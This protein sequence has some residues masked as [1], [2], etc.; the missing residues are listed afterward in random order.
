MRLLLVEDDELFRQ[1]LSKSLA[2][3]HYIIDAV[4]DGKIAWGY[5]KTFSYDL[6][7]LDVLLPGISG[8]DFCRE[9]RAKG[10]KFPILLLSA[11]DTSI[12]RIQGLDAGA[13]DFVA[14]PIDIEE[15][16]ARIRA[17]LRRGQAEASPIL[18]CGPLRIDPNQATT[19]YGGCP[20]HLTSKKYALLELLIRNNQR[21]VSFEKI[22]DSLWSTGECP[23]RDTVRS[24]IKDL[25]QM[26]QAAGAPDNTIATVRGRGYRLTLPP[27]EAKS[28]DSGA[29]LET[30]L[31]ARQAEV[32]ARQDRLWEQYRS[33]FANRLEK[34]SAAVTQLQET[35]CDR[36]VL[37]NAQREAHN[38]AGTL[39]TFGLVEGTRLARELEWAL[40]GEDLPD[41]SQTSLLSSL[42]MA[43]SHEIRTNQTASDQLLKTV[44]QPAGHLT[45][46]QTSL[47]LI[48]GC[49]AHF[50]Q[51][52]V[53][54]AHAAGLRTA[55]A[56]NPEE[57]HQ[58]VAR[59]LP[60]VAL[61][62]LSLLQAIEAGDRSGMR[63]S[64]RQPLPSLVTI[65]LSARDRLCDRLEATRLGASVFLK[66]SVLPAQVLEVIQQQL[67]DR[68][69]AKVIIVDDDP[70][71]LKQ[72]SILLKPWGLEL[73]GLE[74]PR[75]FWTMLDAIQ[76]DLVVL[77]VTM[78]HI[79]GLELCQ[80]IRSDPDWHRL[81]VLFLT[82]HSDPESR[83]QAFA[84][85]ADD[86]V[87]KPVEAAELANR[88]L[89]RLS[90]GQS[91]QLA[92]FTT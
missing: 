37:K 17:L 29:P 18:Q 6:L 47:V 59:E 72:L 58:S 28:K 23:G 60:A 32:L 13:D 11:R 55:I 62:E 70:E 78:P 46:H 66:S 4:P 76:P 15:L 10:F 63:P 43:L 7:L 83:K 24:H 38:L 68:T 71:L 48:A 41:S 8:I 3:R 30:S 49:S 90:R 67:C 19:T 2:E 84:L 65:A 64:T 82:A 52:M 69:G 36:T 92:S 12:N 88:I 85:G 40:Q 39:G 22:F 89:N 26:L 21:V 86:Y 74:D 31:A 9:I 73:T 5:L 87:N 51:H 27:S 34:L 25:R 1:A 61:V 54:L 75:Q 20:I 44:S 50:T 53:R 45:P 91:R 56:S 35:A 16:E 80:V 14:K 81:P 57:V 79:S 42:I 77:D 33:K